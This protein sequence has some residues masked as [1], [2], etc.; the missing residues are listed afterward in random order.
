MKQKITI[1]ETKITI[2]ET[3]IVISETKIAI[4]ETKIAINETK[5]AK[6]KQETKNKFYEYVQLYEYMYNKHSNNS[7]K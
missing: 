3:K 1:N 2:N 6:V 4:S 5:I 7:I